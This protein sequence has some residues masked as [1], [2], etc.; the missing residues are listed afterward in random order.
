MGKNF[1]YEGQEVRKTGRTAERN[2][3]AGRTARTLV[4]VEI[5]PVGDDDSWKKWIDP[6]Q[7]FT[8]KDAT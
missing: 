3:G 5:T 7:L 4:V 6:S 2:V 1:V 8:V